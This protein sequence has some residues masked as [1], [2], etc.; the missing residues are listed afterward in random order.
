MAT[1]GFSTRALLRDITVRSGSDVFN[2]FVNLVTILFLANYLGSTDY[3]IYMQVITTATLLVPLLILRLST[4]SVR[5]FPSICDD[6]GLLKDHVMT[7]LI[8]VVV[9][10]SLAALLLVG[11]TPFSTRLIFGSDM[12][13]RLVM[14]LSLFV[15][16][17]CVAILLIDYFRA[18]NLIIQ[19]SLYNSIRFLAVLAA[20]LLAISGRLDVTG[21]IL[22][23]C[24]AELIVLLLVAARLARRQVFGIPFRFSLDRLSPYFRYSLPLV[25]YS[26][27]LGVNQLSDRYFIAHMIDIDAAGIYAFTYIMVSAAFLLAASLS[28]V[29]YP[30]LSRL[31]QDGEMQ[32]VSRYIDIGQKIFVF[33]GLPIAFGVYVIYRPLVTLLAGDG[34]VVSDAVV[35]W[36]TAGHF[37]F[38]LCCIIGYI[39]DLSKKTVIYLK[40]LLFTS[41]INLLLNWLLI[42]II[43]MQGAAISTAVTYAVQLLALSR[44]S[45]TLVPF[46]VAINRRFLLV[47]LAGSAIMCLL[48]LRLQPADGIAG[49][50]LTVLAG[51][52][53]YITVTLPFTWR[54]LQN[55]VSM[56]GP[57]SRAAK[58]QGHD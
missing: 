4:A 17:R 14:V 45:S 25:P 37:F 53:I 54:M 20:I 7:I 6:N 57:G 13:A 21:I 49:L 29:I 28:Y 38:G 46:R 36:I 12:G 41:L 26:F 30:Y 33:F 35:V 48:L 3:G 19:A 52:I 8:V 42:P 10:S 39:I 44:M 1:D 16:L 15:V 11:M 47:C 56:I 2:V 55:V 50:V 32:E 5:F 51:I 43:G 9:V 24:G 18:L 58:E 22:A 27:F 34:F 23:Q 40:I 31:W